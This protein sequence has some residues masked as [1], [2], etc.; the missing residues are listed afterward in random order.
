VGLIKGRNDRKRD[1]AERK[2][3]FCYEED[4]CLVQCQERKEIVI[5]WFWAMYFKRRNGGMKKALRFLKE[6]QED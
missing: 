4:F 1:E 6:F 5:V 3:P 2:A